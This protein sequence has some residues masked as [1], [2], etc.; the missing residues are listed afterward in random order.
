M[1]LFADQTDWWLCSPNFS[2]ADVALTVLLDRLNA[3]GL[4]ER[5]WSNNK[6]PNVEL[7][8]KRVQSRDSYQKAIPSSLIHLQLLLMMTPRVVGV[9]ACVMAAVAVIVGGYCYLKRK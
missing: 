3:L 9:G 8:F 2:I 1:F 4:Q 7:Y 6:R 5:F